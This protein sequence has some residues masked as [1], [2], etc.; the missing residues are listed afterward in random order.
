M[1][2][3]SG[4]K[5]LIYMLNTIKN[6][7][8]IR[9]F[10]VPQF[11]KNASLINKIRIPIIAFIVLTLVQISINY[12]SFTSLSQD[13]RYQNEIAVMALRL[14]LDA[15]KDLYQALVNER[16]VITLLES[17]TAKDEII[18]RLKKRDKD[19]KSSASRFKNAIELV[20]E[21]SNNSDYKS[22]VDNHKKWVEMSDQAIELARKGDK[23]GAVSLSF[24]A[25][26]I[27]EIARE[28][29]DLVGDRLIDKTKNGRDSMNEKIDSTL[30]LQ[31][32]IAS[33]LIFTMAIVALILPSFI[34]KPAIVLRDTLME[35]SE[36]ESDLTRRLEELSHDELGQIAK[37]YN[38][39]MDK[40]HHSI[41]QVSDTSD[42]LK[43]ST[44]VL[45]KFS[46]ENKLLSR[47]QYDSITVIAAAVEEISS[48]IKDVA[49]NSEEVAEA[50]KTISKSADEGGVVI[51]TASEKVS[52][53]AT[54]MLDSVSV[55]SKLEE[56]ASNIASVMG[57]I[58]GIA[59]QTNL[60]ALNAAIEAARA[61]E[62]GRGFAVVA[63][64]VRSLAS[65]TQS[66]TGDIQTMI[67]R[68]Q[69]GVNDAVTSI[70]QGNELAEETVTDV[71]TAQVAFNSILESLQSV[72]EMSQQIATATEQQS[73]GVLEISSNLT[74]IDV[75]SR[76]TSENAAKV[77]SE[78][79]ASSECMENLTSVVKGFKL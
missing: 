64:E 73:E 5:G 51:Q 62:Y 17:N 39:V 35:L 46:N 16:A 21:A 28:S 9:W 76:K 55:I 32:L 66:S 12:S 48:T 75:K 43:R 8:I 58:S 19:I 49:N 79:K 38:L 25:G 7:P 29:L 56:D 2:K 42:S 61:G 74:D 30:L 45:Q 33:T 15:D 54:K 63:D 68:L 26:K 40:L 10:K 37:A 20:N 1:S 11:I 72:S 77:N 22:F 44:E 18:K 71:S 59:D 31:V 57:V 60:L 14:T 52:S 65:R 41:N 13:V 23:K 69:S 3:M 27:F 50:T 70:Q 53:L 47:E 78:A 34:A 67:N 4:T 36:G 6:L 24:E